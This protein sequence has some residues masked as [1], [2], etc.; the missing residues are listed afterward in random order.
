M[1]RMLKTFADANRGPLTRSTDN[2]TGQVINAKTAKTVLA[3]RKAAPFS[4]SE[5]FVAINSSPLQKARGQPGNNYDELLEN[6][7]R[8][9]GWHRGAL[10][11][12]G[13]TGHDAEG[14][15][16][17]YSGQRQRERGHQPMC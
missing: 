6:L 11:A 8:D 17:Q 4:S 16:L 13:G 10:G 7:R 14:D 12:G 2:A 1:A 9:S 15:E 5:F 3:R